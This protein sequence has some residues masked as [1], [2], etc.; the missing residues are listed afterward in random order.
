M[1]YLS[2]KIL[3]KIDIEYEIKDRDGKILR[4]RKFKGN[5]W[6]GRIIEFLS[7]F[8]G[9]WASASGSYAYLTTRTDVKDTSGTYRHMLMG[10]S[11]GVVYGGQA[12]A[13]DTTAGIILGSS[14]TPVSIDQYDLITRIPHGSGVGQLSYGATTVDLV[15][16][17]NTFRLT[18]TRTFTNNSGSSVV[19]K[20]MGLFLRLSM[21]STPYWYSVMLARDIPPTP[22]E[23]PNGATLT[24]RYIISHSI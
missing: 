15:R 10:G 2:S 20:E 24:V 12:P 18:I 7:S 1:V 11:S 17:T 9:I 13:G 23:V 5:S 21:G 3:S 22:I 16:E 19:V 8:I 6:V 14:N 4:K